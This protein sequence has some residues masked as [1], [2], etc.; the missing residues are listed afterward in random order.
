MDH[1]EKDLVVDALSNMVNKV[2]QNLILMSKIMQGLSAT[3]RGVGFDQPFMSMLEKG[4]L[5]DYSVDMTPDQKKRL[6]KLLEQRRMR[7]ITNMYSGR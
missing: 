6:Q 7:D 3:T 1:L 5:G 2:S 4:R